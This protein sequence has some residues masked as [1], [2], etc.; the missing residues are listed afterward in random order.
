M[1]EG[2][3]V[4]LVS[5]AGGDQYNSTNLNSIADRLGFSFSGDFLAHEEILRRMIFIRQYVKE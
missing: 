1:R 4:V 2:G 3:A 5:N